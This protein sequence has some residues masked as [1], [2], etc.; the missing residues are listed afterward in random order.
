MLP[1]LPDFDAYSMG[2]DNVVASR[3]ALHFYSTS[4]STSPSSPKMH[5]LRER[6]E[7]AHKKMIES[8]ANLTDQEGFVQMYF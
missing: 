2:R 8:G 6:D 1:I 5:E 3:G 4:Y 7:F